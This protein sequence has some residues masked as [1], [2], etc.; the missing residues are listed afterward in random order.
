[1]K[2]MLLLAAVIFMNGCVYRQGKFP[3]LSNK[4]VDT[5]DFTL[6]TSKHG[7]PVEG[8]DSGYVVVIYPF[9]EPSLGEAMNQALRSAK[10][11]VMT[12]ATLEYQ[13]WYI[14]YIYGETHWVVKGDAI[15]TRPH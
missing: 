1:M 5:S 15:R 13:F 6:D 8:E 9:G 3:V 7:I 4:L 12:N 10:S 2:K 14:P 11:D